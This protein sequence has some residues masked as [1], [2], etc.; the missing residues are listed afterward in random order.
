MDGTLTALFVLEKVWSVKI[1]QVFLGEAETVVAAE[2][3][4]LALVTN[5]IET[6][7]P[8]RQSLIINGAMNITKK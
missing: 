7:G 8:K 1:T 6:I 5:S 4:C 3:E 2:Q